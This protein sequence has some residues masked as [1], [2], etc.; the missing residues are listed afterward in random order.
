M[1]GHP[2]KIWDMQGLKN[3]YNVGAHA[4]GFESVKNIFKYIDALFLRN[5]L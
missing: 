2:W 1:S 5:K 3:V 4:S